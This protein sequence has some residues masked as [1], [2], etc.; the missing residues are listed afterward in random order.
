MMHKNDRINSSV[1]MLP[2]F[3]IRT[4]KPIHSNALCLIAIF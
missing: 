2:L 4:R 3:E 1:V